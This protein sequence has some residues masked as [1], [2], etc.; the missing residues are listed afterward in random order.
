MGNGLVNR[1]FVSLERSQEIICV[2]L[3]WYGPLDRMVLHSRAQLMGND[4]IRWVMAGVKTYKR[5]PP[6]YPLGEWGWPALVGS[7]V[8]AD[9]IERMDEIGEFGGFGPIDKIRADKADQQRIVEIAE[10]EATRE[11]LREEFGH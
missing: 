3:T 10:A 11:R 4:R 5:T 9:R 6:V 7:L 8:R 2:L 1:R